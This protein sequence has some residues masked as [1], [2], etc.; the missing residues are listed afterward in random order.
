MRLILLTALA[1]TA[2]AASSVL[3]RMAP[4]LDGVETASFAAIGR[5]VDRLPVR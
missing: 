3:G 4:V 5:C 2:F 1:M